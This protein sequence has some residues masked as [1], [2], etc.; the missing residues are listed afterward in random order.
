M[1]IKIN[2]VTSDKFNVPLQNFKSYYNDPFYARF[3]INGNFTGGMGSR[4]G[5]GG[6]EGEDRSMQI[7]REKGGWEG[8]DRSMQIPREM[9][10]GGW[11]G[12]AGKGRTGVCKYPEKWGEGG[13]GRGGLEYANT[14]RTGVCKYPVGNSYV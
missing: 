10:E 6:W 4:Q 13:L 8:E 14:P 12:G 7:S 2:W 5:G 1:L 11:E 9:G 3:A